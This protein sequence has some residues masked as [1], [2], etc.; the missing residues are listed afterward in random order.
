[1]SEKRQLGRG[2]LQELMW[3]LMNVLALEEH[4]AETP[5]DEL[6]LL[7]A[8]AMRAETLE[9]I[10]QLLSGKKPSETMLMRYWCIVKHLLLASIHSFEA[11]GQIV[12][13][14]PNESLEMLELSRATFSR[15]EEL[16]VKYAS[17]PIEEKE[18]QEAEEEKHSA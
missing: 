9:K 12:D 8:R 2:T 6:T 4:L 10:T 13:T 15:A 14:S 16:L 11:A 1:L 5:M 3:L 17:Q 18:K 7:D